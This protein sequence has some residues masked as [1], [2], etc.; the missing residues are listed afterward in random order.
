[1]AWGTFKTWAIKP[2]GE[3]DDDKSRRILEIARRN[4]GQITAMAAAIDAD[5]E[6]DESKILLENLVDK[7]IAVL[8]VTD[9]ASLL[10]CFPDL[11]AS[12]HIITRPLSSD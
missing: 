4:G 9:D 2:P 12:N 5:L 11:R 6:I 1:M 3:S 10:Y 8:E 7:G